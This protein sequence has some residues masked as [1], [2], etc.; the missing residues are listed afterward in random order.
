MD[1]YPGLKVSGK[2][3]V[4]PGSCDRTAILQQ[5]M[6]CDSEQKQGKQQPQKSQTAASL[7]NIP[8]ESSW[9]NLKKNMVR[10]TA[11]M[12]LLMAAVAGAPPKR[13]DQSNQV[14]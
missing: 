8:G 14:H 3:F 12:R 1:P 5:A 11:E 13:T 4:P 10:Q 9:R 2:M 7:A 6:Q